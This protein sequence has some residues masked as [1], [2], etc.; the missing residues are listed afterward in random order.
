MG[1][2]V[3]PKTLNE[4]C[5]PYDEVFSTAN[6]AAVIKQVAFPVTKERTVVKCDG[7]SEWLQKG[8]RCSYLNT[9]ENATPLQNRIVV[10][11][12]EFDYYS[13]PE[14]MAELNRKGIEIAIDKR[15]AL[16]FQQAILCYKM[17][18]FVFSTRGA[19]AQIG[20]APKFTLEDTKGRCLSMP[21]QAAHSSTIPTLM[22]RAK[23]GSTAEFVYLKGGGSYH[24]HNAAVSM[25]ASINKADT[26]IDGKEKENKLRTTTLHLLNRVAQGLDPVAAT[27]EFCHA[28]ETQ[29]R[30]SA[31][32]LKLHDPRKAVL[33]LYERNII[34][35]QAS[36]N[37]PQSFDQLL[38][39]IV[40]IAH[41]HEAKLREVVYHKRYAILQYQER[42]ECQIAHHM[43]EM[44]KLMNAEGS[45]LEDMILK[46]F[47]EPHERK[48]IEKLFGRNA[49]WL[50]NPHPELALKA[51]QTKIETLRTKYR[52]PLQN[53]TRDLR[54]DFRS[55]S[56]AEFTYRAGVFKDLRTTVHGW[57]QEE[58]RKKYLET[59]GY[60]VSRSW[61]SRMEQLSRIPTKIHYA[62]PTNQRRKYVTVSEAQRC[63][64]TFGVSAGFFFPGLFTSSE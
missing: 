4:Y 50:E 32:T 61:I 37:H 19:D 58:F 2:Y 11:P 48:M 26:L 14:G 33:Q 10:T 5:Q 46:E 38:G 6:N 30:L 25:H 8:S 39:V 53:L 64:K 23:D 9:G 34:Q 1:L 17:S 51:Y 63:A 36:L 45:F 56:C 49:A 60:S 55:L 28:F 62:T 22:A 16:F 40:G 42:I 31:G 47:Y 44:Q 52:I 20:S 35:L 54:A 59:T 21:R 7:I 3:H 57:T 29:V 27:K 15:V 43:A 41:P 18:D 12:A 13:T 24:D